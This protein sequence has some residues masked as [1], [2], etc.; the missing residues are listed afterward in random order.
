MRKRR[1][2]RHNGP[3]PILAGIATVLGGGTLAL[4]GIALLPVPEEHW[5]RAAI[6]HV[7][8]PAALFFGAS[9]ISKANA[10][11]IRVGAVILG[12]FGSIGAYAAYK[13]IRVPAVGDTV[14]VPASKL[15][16]PTGA[17][18]LP[19]SSAVVALK[20]IAVDPVRMLASGDGSAVGLGASPV[21]FTFADV[22]H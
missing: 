17:Q 20:V 18:A 8:T 9:K 3:H 15:T 21:Q 19:T 12:I 1:H 13:A 11:G 5:K 22:V 16:T 10:G 7:V 2:T 4:G 6:W 14:Q